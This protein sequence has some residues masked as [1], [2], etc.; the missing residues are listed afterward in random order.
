MPRRLAKVQSSVMQ[1]KVTLGHVEPDVWRRL[2]VPADVDLAKLHAIINEA[3]GWTNR[4]SC[5]HS[6]TAVLGDC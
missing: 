4:A 1:L 2:L 3:M 6:R 5:D